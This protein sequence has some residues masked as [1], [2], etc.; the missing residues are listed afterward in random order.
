MIWRGAVDAGVYCYYCS[1]LFSGGDG[2]RVYVAGPYSADN[3]LQ[4][5]RNMRQA[6]K[7]ASHLLK[8]GL[9]PFCPH[10]DYHFELVENHELEDFYRYSMDWLE[11]SDCVVLLPGWEESKGCQA[12]KARAEELDIPV[13]PI[14][15]FLITLAM[16]RM[17]HEPK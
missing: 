7:A 3:V 5:L 4:V 13:A 6:Q 9:S 2:L 17:Q 12:E 1:V 11:V 10:L 16:E 8:I 14:K 15:E